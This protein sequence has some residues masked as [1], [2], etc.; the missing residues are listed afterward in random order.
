MGSAVT[1]EGVLAHLSPA[2]RER[3]AG[4]QQPQVRARIEALT[5]PVKRAA[6][7]TPV[8]ASEVLHSLVYQPRGLLVVLKGL[9][10]VSAANAHEEHFAR[11]ARVKAERAAVAR[12]LAGVAPI[13]DPRHVH[14]TRI[15]RGELDTDNLAGACKAVRDEIARWLGVD[16]GPR[17]P[18]TWEVAQTRGDGYAVRIE[19]TGGDQ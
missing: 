5:K 3:L 9:R 18:V 7:P 13:S 8:R 19:I 12:A 11:H 17:G 4:I 14:I 2:Q 16:D 1:L 10:L 6:S 15:A